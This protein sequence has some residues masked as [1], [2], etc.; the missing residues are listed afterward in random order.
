MEHS[1]STATS[2]SENEFGPEDRGRYHHPGEIGGIEWNLLE[3]LVLAAIDADHKTQNSIRRH[4]D[5]ARDFNLAPVL[6]GMEIDRKIKKHS[7]GTFSAWFRYDQRPVKWWLDGDGKVAYELDQ[8]FI[9]RDPNEEKQKAEQFAAWGSRGGSDDPIP[10]PDENFDPAETAVKRGGNRGGGR[11]AKDLD[12]FEV[13]EIAATTKTKNDIAKA[14]G[15]TKSS[16]L[17]QRIRTDNEVRD[18]YDRG[19]K[20]FSETLGIHAGKPSRAETEKDE[21]EAAAARP[22]KTSDKQLAHE[23]DLKEVAR[24]AREGSSIDDAANFFFLSKSQFKNLLSGVTKSNGVREA[25]YGAQKV[26]GVNLRVNR[27]LATKARST[28]KP[29]RIP[30]AESVEPKTGAGRGKK[31][32][33][34]AGQLEELASTLA[35]KLEIAKALGYGN[36]TTP[37]D[38]RFA[39]EPKL[40]AAYDRGR[41][42][43]AKTDPDAKRSASNRK[44]LVKPVSAELI[45]KPAAG[46]VMEI[47]ETEQPGW[48]SRVMKSLARMHHKEIRF[49]RGGVV[50]LTFDGNVFDS[51]AE[52]LTLIGNIGELIRDF[53][54]ERSQAR[55]ASDN[56]RSDGQ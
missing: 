24:L 2:I 51:S 16:G 36:S 52:E 53:N 15:F 25:W 23:L 1:A 55:R 5:L 35:T 41:K 28:P 18:A 13:E 7:N 4:A 37:L 6:E 29:K 49:D 12:L 8:N 56:E 46:I 34:S 9:P 21:R 39:K 42:A 30:A 32:E 22:R 47:D 40:K 33:I 38:R 54:V 48:E 3:K 20:R 26:A 45:E 31:I 43:Y 10:K 11:K 50:D 17:D 14:L 27:P 44:A 19:R